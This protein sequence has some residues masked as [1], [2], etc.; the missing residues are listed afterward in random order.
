MRGG[1]I[2][3]EPEKGATALSR[4]RSG[5]AAFELRAVGGCNIVA[6]TMLSKHQ[7]IVSGYA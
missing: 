7:S 3:Q 4:Q 6:G 2:P 1:D 5:H